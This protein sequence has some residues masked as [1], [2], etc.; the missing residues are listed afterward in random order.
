MLPS[1]LSLWQ[2]LEFSMKWEARVQV[3]FITPNVTFMV[4]PPFYDR[5]SGNSYRRQ[6]TDFILKNVDRVRSTTR[7][8]TFD[9]KA[10]LG[11]IGPSMTAFNHK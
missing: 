1:L 9:L 6:F 10:V 11:V 5:V 8:V 7:Q 3:F 4:S 2:L